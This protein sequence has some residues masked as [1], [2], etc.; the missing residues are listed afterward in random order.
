MPTCTCSMSMQVLGG[1]DEEAWEA[2]EQVVVEVHSNAALTP[3][4]QALEQRFSRV[5]HEQSPHM[6]GTQLHMV[7]ATRGQLSSQD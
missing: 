1:I 4:L 7:Y 2:V 6:Q 5:L 3:V